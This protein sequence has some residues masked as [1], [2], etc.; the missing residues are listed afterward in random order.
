MDE[1]NTL[2]HDQ[3]SRRSIP[4]VQRVPLEMIFSKRIMSSKIEKCPDAI[5]QMR[6]RIYIDTGLCGDRSFEQSPRL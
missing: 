1:T 6:M 5:E 4:S 2:I 3:H